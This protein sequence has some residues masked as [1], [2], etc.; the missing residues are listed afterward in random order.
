MKQTYVTDKTFKNIDF[1]QKLL[2]V[3]EYENCIFRNC[4]FEYANLS[5]FKFTGCEFIESNLSMTKLI[6]TAFRDVVFKN[7]KMFG[8][9]FQFEDC[10]LDHSIFY[11]A[12]IRK[13]IFR[14]SKLNG[15]DFSEANISGSIILNCDLSGAVFDQTNLENADLRD[16]FNYIINPIGNKLKNAQFS[17]SGISGLLHSFDIKIDK[18]N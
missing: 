18:N 2:E 9:S 13:T 8:M 3:G 1:E 7:C 5:G 6:G 14:N 15:V 17:L 10:I 11:Q 16:S 12:D 4:N